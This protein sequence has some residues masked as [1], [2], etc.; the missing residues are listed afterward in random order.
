[1]K[2][3]NQQYFSTKE[4][5]IPSSKLLE[6]EVYSINSKNTITQ[7]GKQ[8]KKSS[9]TEF[10]GMDVTKSLDVVHKISRTDVNYIALD[11]GIKKKSKYSRSESSN[12]STKDPMTISQNNWNSMTQPAKT[13]GDSN[14]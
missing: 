9:A 14:E 1:M 8:N 2:V 5:K 12:T 4:V 10:G 11:S 3:A 7:A 6:S 13:K